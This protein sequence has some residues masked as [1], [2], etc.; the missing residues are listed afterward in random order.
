MELITQLYKQDIP[1]LI[2]G[3]F[4]VISAIITI[5][6]IIGKFSKIIGKPVKWVR[7][8]EKDHALLLQTI[9]RVDILQEEH[10]ESVKQSI[11]HDELIRSDL[12][13]LTDL[14]VEKQIN[15]YRWEIINFSNRIA[16]GEV[17]NKDSY[18]HCFSTYEKYEKLLKEN[19]MKNGEVEISMEV[20]NESYKNKTKPKGM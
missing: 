12:K 16:N 7:E 5:Y 11:R 8:K 4:I 15:D 17:C 18:R 19:G 3:I 10:D 2:F 1:S 14:F 20:I 6:E 9:K 13:N